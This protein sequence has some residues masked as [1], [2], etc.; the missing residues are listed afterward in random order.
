MRDDPIELLKEIKRKM[1]DPKVAKYG[2]ASLT[3]SLRRILNT[4]QLEGEDLI[5]YTKR[6]NQAKDIVKDTV[7]KHIFSLFVESK[8]VYKEATSNKE[9]QEIKAELYGR[10]TSYLYIEN[11]DHRKHEPIMQ[12]LTCLLYTSPSPRDRG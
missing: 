9:K 1:Y 5:D 11:S 7:G 8:Q 4:K 12:N 6:F 10:W 2:Y 3:G